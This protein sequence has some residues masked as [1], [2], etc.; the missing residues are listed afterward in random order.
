M[1]RR[2]RTIPSVS[3]WVTKPLLRAPRAH[4]EE[5]EDFDARGMRSIFG[6]VDQFPGLPA[7]HLDL[8]LAKGNRVFVRFSSRGSYVGRCSYELHEFK[9]TRETIDGVARY[10]REALTPPI[11]RIAYDEWLDDRITYPYE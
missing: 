9:I 4:L 8:W 10:D 3:A 7:F 2:S 11:V 6:R 5:L 1:S